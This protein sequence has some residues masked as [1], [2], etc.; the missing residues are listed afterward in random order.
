M[1]VEPRL[2]LGVGP[3]AEPPAVLER[4]RER[5]GRQVAR[6]L[7]VERRCRASMIL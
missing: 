1:P 6:D 5:L 2:R 7:D 4:L 3:P